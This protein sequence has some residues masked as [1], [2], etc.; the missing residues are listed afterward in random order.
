MVGYI[1]GASALHTSLA[2]SMVALT[3]CT[4]PQP[5]PFSSHSSEIAPSPPSAATAEPEYFR[6]PPSEAEAQI[7]E[8]LARDIGDARVVA[9]GEHS[10]FAGAT[11]DIKLKLVEFLHRRLGFARIV[12][13]AGLFSC[14]AA[15]E[16]E[17]PR[18]AA[19]L[20]LAGKDPC[21]SRSYPILEYAEWT[22]QHG[23]ALAFSGMDP[24]LS[25]NA[26]SKELLV[27]RLSEALGAPLDPAQ[28]AAI[29]N[30]FSLEAVRTLDERSNDRDILLALSGR[31]RQRLGVESFWARV[32]DGLVF[33]DEDHW[34]FQAKK[35]ITIEMVSLRNREMG[36]NIL[37]LLDHHPGERLIL[38]LASIHASRTHAGLVLPEQLPRYLR[39]DNSVPAGQWVAES[40]GQKYFVLGVTAASGETAEAEPKLGPA[41]PDMV[42]YG[43]LSRQ[44]EV[45]LLLKSQL[46]EKGTCQGLAM[47]GPVEMDWAR[48]F[49]ALLV[50]QR[51]RPLNL[52]GCTR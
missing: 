7:F 40:L 51:E 9:L 23:P 21:R 3:A 47:G 38:S 46:A 31:A 22:R 8:R 4:S 33:I 32:M 37:W 18:A 42:E 26:A 49:D 45:E 24:Q 30:L 5:R 50:L 29:R 25:G 44:S 28:E 41:T 52:S 6:S 34:D 39:R 13:E 48:A 27:S 16:A 12:F 20:C 17:S 36:K 2:I 19:E 43:V 15:E 10:H 11:T 1:P 35:K 14:A